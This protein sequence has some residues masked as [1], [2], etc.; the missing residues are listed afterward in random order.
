MSTEPED[1]YWR[2]TWPQFTRKVKGLY[3]IMPW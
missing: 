3:F 2:G 1:Y